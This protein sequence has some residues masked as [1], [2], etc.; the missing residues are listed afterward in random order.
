MPLTAS[1]CVRLQHY[2]NAA[3][4]FVAEG[5]IHG[6][7][8]LQ[9]HCVGDDERRIDLTGLDFL[10]QRASVAL[11]V[12]LAGTVGSVLTGNIESQGRATV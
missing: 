8:V 3:I 1:V 6:R 2:L 7:R 11:D 9:I 5:L 10:E 4:L 12:G